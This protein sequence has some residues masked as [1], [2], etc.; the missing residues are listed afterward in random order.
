MK[1]QLLFLIAL[2]GVSLLHAQN[3]VPE[4]RIVV[5]FKAGATVTVPWQ[6]DPALIR[7]FREKAFDRVEVCGSRKD[8]AHRFYV[9]TWNT[10]VQAD[11]LIKTISTSPLV[12]YA[13]SDVI[14]SG[15][16]VQQVT[17]NDQYY[18]NRQWG[19]KNDGTFSLSTAL[20]GADVDMENAWNIGQGSSNVVLG[21]IDSGTKLDHPEFSGRLWTN[22]GEIAGNNIDDDSNGYVDDINGWDFANNDNDPTDDQGHGSNVAGIACATGNNSIGYAGIDWN[23]KLMTLKGL[24]SSNS[25]FYSWWADALY[26]AVDNGV[27]V[28]NMSLGGTGS[29]TLLQ[30]AVNYALSNNV[31]V[32]VAMGNGNTNA[33]FYPAVYSGVIAVGSTNADDTR[34][35]PFFWSTTSGSNYGNHI[36]VVAPGNYIYGLSHTSNTNYNSYWG[37]TSQASPLVAGIATLLLGQTPGLAPAQ[38]KSLIEATAEDQVGNSN[39]DVAGFDPYYGHGRVN[40]ANALSVMT[41]VKPVASSEGVAVYP[42]P[43]VIGSSF[44][45]SCPAATIAVRVYTASGTLL[46]QLPA[47]RSQVL[48]LTMDIPGVYIVQVETG[49]GLITKKV[50]VTR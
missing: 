16:G 32:V 12:N 40:A 50:V 31:T 24:N 26:Y 48:Q 36:S 20:A 14:G 30:T 44:T 41:A 46:Q 34:T 28:I 15:T 17:P 7:L 29:S 2:F 37:G 35:V 23:C 21:V 6:N 27:H 47:N 42:N 38:I 8:A 9:F 43:I 5:S 25:G 22:S 49:T 1:K 18:Y 10:P 19:L 3:G 39:E 11:E 4:T 33:A 45:V 13:E